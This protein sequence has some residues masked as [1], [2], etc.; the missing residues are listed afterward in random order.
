MV[1]ANTLAPTIAAAPPR[2]AAARTRNGVAARAARQPTPWLTLFAVSSPR[3]G[4]HLRVAATSPMT[5]H[6][7][8]SNVWLSPHLAQPCLAQ[9]TTMCP[10]QAHRAGHPLAEAYAP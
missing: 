2:R 7:T 4:T 5:S 6:L 8:R 1:P 10:L 3:E 9:P